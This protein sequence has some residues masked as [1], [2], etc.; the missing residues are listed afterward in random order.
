[1]I[2]PSLLIKTFCFLVA[3]ALASACNN[4][5][6][7]VGEDVESPTPLFGTKILL[8]SGLGEVNTSMTNARGEVVGVRCSTCH[9]MELGGDVPARKAEELKDFH[10]DMKFN[11]GTLD[12]QSCHN[13]KD[14]DT[15]RLANGDSLAFADTMQLCAQCHGPQMRNYNDG[16][17]GVM[18]GYWDLSKGPRV[19]NSC[20]HCHDVHN[21]AFPIASPVF[22]PR[23]RFLTSEKETHHE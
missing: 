6:F 4:K 9:S 17:H 10:K 2:M 20:M 3:C 1:M 7:E 14:R 22:A 16:S 18:N 15:L 13:P 23:D 19:R 21:P 8:P 5:E 12:C 11:H